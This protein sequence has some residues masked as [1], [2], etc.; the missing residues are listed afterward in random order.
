MSQMSS[1]VLNLR[2]KGDRLFSLFIRISSLLPVLTMVLILLTLVNH[3]MGTVAV[4]EGRIVA[5]WPLLQ[6]ALFHKQI[7]ETVF[8]PDQPVEYT[9]RFWLSPAFLASSPS[10]RPETTGLSAAL[11]GSA[12]IILLGLAVS[13]PIALSTA[14]WAS[15]GEEGSLQSRILN[16]LL[17]IYR[18]IPNVLFGLCSLALFSRLSRASGA[19]GLRSLGSAGFLMALVLLPR[20]TVM[21][22]REMS[23]IPR[24]TLRAS[25]ALGAHRQTVLFRQVLPASIGMILAETIRII[26]GIAGLASP[27]IV[28]GAASYLSAAPTRLQDHFTTVSVQIFQWSLRPEGSYRNLAASA[29]LFLLLVICLLQ[30]VS[31][32]WRHRIIRMREGLR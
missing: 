7:R 4:S 21:M 16:T 11:T 20:L 15:P 3:S 2:R 9:F 28:L 13:F 25:Y 31:Y 29:A 14:M 8:F 18:R 22:H 26:A 12:W 19:P 17:N 24:S 32:L 27:F 6:S 23:A 10:S 5:D 30:L 1:P